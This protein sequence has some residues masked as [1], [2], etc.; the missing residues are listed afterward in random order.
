MQNFD[1]QKA[2]S[3]TPSCQQI[4]HFNNAGAALM[5]SP[6]VQ[7]LL[8]YTQLEA[9]IGGYEA[10]N[11]EE[12]KIKGVYQAA[13]R[14]LRCQPQ[15]IAFVESATRGWSL[16][17]Y[18]I[19]FRKGD[20]ILTGMSE[21]ESN[22]LAFLQAVKKYGVQIQVIPNDQ[23]G[24][25]SIR[26]LEKRITK[27]VK[28]IAI[29]HI[30]TNGGLVNPAEEIGRIA[31]SE[32]I[33]FLLDSCQAAGQL[34]LDVKKLKC[35]FLSFTGRKY[36]RGPR[37]T[38]IL[39][40]KNSVCNRLEPPMLDLQAAEWIS[41]HQYRLSRGAQRFEQW[42]TNCGAK[43]ALGI[44]IDYAMS[45]T[46]EAIEARVFQL[47][48]L[49]RS[50]LNAIRGVSVT[51][52]GV[53]QC[54]IV[55]FKVEGKDPTWIKQK[56]FENKINTSVSIKRYT[57]MDMQSRKIPALCRASVHYYNTEQEIEKFGEILEGLAR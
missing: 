8:N 17:F 18:S 57:R 46:T 36:I 23:F 44:A 45:W 52:L 26:E 25:V 53:R 51:D 34:D 39:Y 30:P 41:A 13:S 15:E 9:E 10:A 1:V 19:P 22:Y 49:L 42:E 4:L 31:T 29:T 55:S 28:L 12:S 6:V 35:D 50:R 14:L 33:L 7:S 40:V 3:E 32:K 43:L 21:Y 38:G 20:V 48:N 54:G 16:A 24:Q 27:K 37:G 56:L 11:Q 47:G 2:R 5:P